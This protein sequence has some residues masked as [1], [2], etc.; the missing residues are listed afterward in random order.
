MHQ[1][2][3]TKPEPWHNAWSDHTNHMY[4]QNHRH[5]AIHSTQ[6]FEIQ[7]HLVNTSIIWTR[8]VACHAWR[9]KTW[10]PGGF[11]HLIH[12]VRIHHHRWCPFRVPQVQ[13]HKVQEVVQ[14]YQAFLRNIRVS[15]ESSFGPGVNLSFGPEANRF[16]DTKIW[17]HK[18]NEGNVKRSF[19]MSKLEH[20]IHPSLLLR[21]A[22]RGAAFHLFCYVLV[23]IGFVF[24]FALAVSPCKH[25]SFDICVYIHHHRDV[26]ILHT[27][28][29]TTYRKTCFFAALHPDIHRLPNI[30]LI[31]DKQICMHVLV[32]PSCLA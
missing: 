7:R 6:F 12:R 11:R 24:S 22:T 17:N 1:Q 13:L 10:G 26:Y 14:I 5:H 30:P 18:S 9:P 20:N 2:C 3:T 23:T 21:S 19:N 25:P 29:N 4:T 15:R 28:Y 31:D 8:S 32:V 16:G 27:I